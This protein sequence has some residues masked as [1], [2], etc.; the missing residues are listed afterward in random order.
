MARG[1]S[2]QFA[3]VLAIFAVWPKVV[4]ALGGGLDKYGCHHD[5]RPCGYH[6]HRVG[7]MPRPA[8]PGESL[9]S[10]K[11]DPPSASA[12]PRL[13]A[14]AVRE[15]LHASCSRTRDAVERLACYDRFAQADEIERKQ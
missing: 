11:K 14:G 3:C 9:H 4:I 8:E 1:M 12:Q 5:S 2:I 6:C 7:Y 13:E 15:N 10:P